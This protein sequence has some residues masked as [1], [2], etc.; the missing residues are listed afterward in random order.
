MTSVC[1]THHCEFNLMLKQWLLKPLQDSWWSL[2]SIWQPNVE[3]SKPHWVKHHVKYIIGLSGSVE[4]KM[5]SHLHHPLLQF[6]VLRIWNSLQYWLDIWYS[7]G[8]NLY[9][10]LSPIKNIIKGYGI[11]IGNEDRDTPCIHC[12]HNPRTCHFRT[13]WAQ[14]EL[15][16]PH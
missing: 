7:L 15:R 14:A 4:L 12:L 2:K 13:T 6:Q 1:L 3:P 11:V 8:W 10:K 5:P 16:L 9:R